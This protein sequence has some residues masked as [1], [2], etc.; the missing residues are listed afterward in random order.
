MLEIDG[1]EQEDQP[2]L[3]DAPVLIQRK[4]ISSIFKTPNK[5]Q[6]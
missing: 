4:T 5:K 6:H 1:R 2:V 3:A